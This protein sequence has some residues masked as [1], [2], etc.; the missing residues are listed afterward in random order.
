MIIVRFLVI[1]VESFALYRVED[2]QDDSGDCHRRPLDVEDWQGD[3]KHEIAT[4]N[5]V[6]YDKE[7]AP[8]AHQT[9]SI[10]STQ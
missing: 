2:D 10:C 9:S 5:A 6:R 8:Y 7:P 3:R 1:Y 4:D